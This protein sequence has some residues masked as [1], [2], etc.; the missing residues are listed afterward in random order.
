MTT[1]TPKR[2][3]RYWAIGFK[4]WVEIRRSVDQPK[5]I[6]TEAVRQ[7]KA[8]MPGYGNEWVNQQTKIVSVVYEGGKVIGR[9]RLRDWWDYVPRAV[10]PDVM[11][12]LSKEHLARVKEFLQHE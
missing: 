12:E 7:F 9:M 5:L 6:K 10:M 3:F 8:R 2:K 4:G 11:F 1:A